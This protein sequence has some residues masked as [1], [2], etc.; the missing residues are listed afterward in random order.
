[1]TTISSNQSLTQSQADTSGWPI[2][3]AANVTVTLSGNFTLD[4]TNEYFIIGGANAVLDGNEQT[5]TVT[6][7]AYNGLVQNGTNYPSSVAGYTSTVKDITV[8][9]SGSGA[10]AASGGWIG[11]FGYSTLATSTIS[12]CISTGDITTSYGGGIVGSGPGSA[13]N[14]TISHCYTTGNIASTAECAG[15]IFGEKSGANSGA[16][17]VNDCYTTGT[18]AGLYSGNIGGCK[19]GTNSGT[20]VLNRCYSTGAT[21]GT[22]AGSVLGI[23]CSIVS[24]TVTLNNVYT[25]GAI[26]GS[27]AYAISNSIHTGTLNINNS[28]FPKAVGAGSSGS[29][30]GYHVLTGGD[31]PTINLTNVDWT[32]TSGTWNNTEATATLNQSSGSGKWTTTDTPWT[33]TAFASGGGGGDPYI[34]TI[35]GDTYKLPDGVKVFRMFETC[36]SGKRFIFNCLAKYPEKVL[37]EEMNVI[38]SKM[39]NN[40][41]RE[42]IRNNRLKVEP[43]NNMTFFRYGMLQYG[44]ERLYVDMESLEFFN[45]YKD[46]I[47]GIGACSE[48]PGWIKIV[49]NLERGWINNNL[50][51]GVNNLYKNDSCYPFKINILTESHG[52]IG[53]E[54]YKYNNPQIRTGVQLWCGERKGIRGALVSRTKPRNII[55]KNLNDI[56]PIKD[57]KY[58]SNKWVEETFMQNGMTQKIRIKC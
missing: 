8:A 29:N 37:N 43:I 14:L 1:M 45:C 13:G 28:Y 5:V 48:F 27:N 34:T 50:L 49:G 38:S 26:T 15:G 40:Y 25:Y 36:S 7:A 22:G 18:N 35:W 12:G 55:L 3:I 30:L 44:E 19:A 57:V 52:E 51:S 39:N 4:A 41:I 32:S 17:T 16:L 2:T 47:N 33:L 24:G 21:T 23:Y 56:R 20:I 54:F 11:H 53:I 42:H 58:N 46:M 6:V 31:A 10:L 9:S